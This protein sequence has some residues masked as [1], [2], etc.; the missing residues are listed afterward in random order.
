MPKIIS[1]EE[2][3]EQGLINYFTGEYCVNGHLSTRNVKSK[4]CSECMKIHKK[5]YYKTDSYKKIKKKQN[6]RF[7]QSLKDNPSKL[8][9]F[10]SKQLEYRKS[11][12]G[13]SKRKKYMDEYIEQ[14]EVQKRMKE[15]SDILRKSDKGRAQRNAWMKSSY[16]N[17]IKHLEYNMRSRVNKIMT[18]KQRVKTKH[19]FE[20]IGCTSEELKA[21]IEKLF[22]KKMTWKNYGKWH[23]D[24]IIPLAHFEKHFDMNEVYNQKIAFNFNNLQP[25]WAEENLQK[26]DKISIKVAKKKIAEIRALLSK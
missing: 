8:A 6:E 12:H 22:E 20:L 10:K 3:K 9:K 16:K 11:E 2:A 21:H 1:R 4:V 7:L 24:H 13:K 19:T 14:P 15:T 18:G 23:V 25:M 26:K 5:K 17:P